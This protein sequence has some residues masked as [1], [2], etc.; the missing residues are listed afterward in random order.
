MAA[1]PAQQPEKL[2]DWTAQLKGEKKKDG[3][4]Y[5]EGQGH[6]NQPE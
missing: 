4:S 6:C 1:G 2:L 3:N 5:S